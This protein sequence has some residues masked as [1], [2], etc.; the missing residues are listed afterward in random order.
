MADAN[1]NTHPLVPHIPQDVPVG[2]PPVPSHHQMQ[3][4]EELE[5]GDMSGEQRVVVRPTDCILILFP[6]F[7]DGCLS[8]L[9][10]HINDDRILKF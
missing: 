2:L 5:L 8:Q 10:I 7:A 6:P 1:S 9:F 4:D 3:H